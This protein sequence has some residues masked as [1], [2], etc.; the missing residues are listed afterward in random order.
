[1]KVVV[2]NLLFE[3]WHFFPVNFFFY[4]VSRPSAGGKTTGKHE[5]SVS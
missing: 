4:L 5:V 3:V 2:L 1:M